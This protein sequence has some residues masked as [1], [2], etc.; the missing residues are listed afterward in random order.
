[1]F[2]D[3]SN[4]HERIVELWVQSHLSALDAYP[5]SYGTVSALLT[6]RGQT[7]V[8]PVLEDAE[9]ASTGYGGGGR[10]MPERRYKVAPGNGG[11]GLVRILVSK[12]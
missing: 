9:K 6:A 8:A 2:S 11:G 1:M 3:F 7:F 10:N 4:M 5:T 12:V